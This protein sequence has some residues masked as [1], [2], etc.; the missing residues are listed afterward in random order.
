MRPRC[1]DSLSCRLQQRLCVLL[2]RRKRP[3]A[4]SFHNALRP[5]AALAAL[6]LLQLAGG[7]S[8]ANCTAQQFARL[9]AR[10]T[11]ACCAGGSTSG[12]YQ[13]VKANAQCNSTEID[14]G[15]APTLAGCA[16]ACKAHNAQVAL[17]AS[18]SGGH[19]HGMLCQYFIYGNS[20][21]KQATWCRMEQAQ[22][23]ACS[24]GFIADPGYS[25]YK[26]DGAVPI[27]SGA[28]SAP[29]CGGMGLNVFPTQCSA[30][31]AIE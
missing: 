13:L 17:R 18:A 26:L 25:I 19:K 6:C 28:G 15:P 31:C 29:R 3:A 22:A 7:A 10:T 23:S 1:A 16:L 30:T 11:S 14:L 21:H 9:A 20:G 4:V 12:S 8:A 5:A 27:G 24:A 2:P